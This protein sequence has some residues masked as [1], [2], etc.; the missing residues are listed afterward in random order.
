M[1][2]V[3]I[4]QDE[5]SVEARLFELFGVTSDELR[6]VVEQAA[7]ARADCVA[8]DP[9]TA[10]GTLA[11]FYGTRGLRALFRANGWERD[12][13]GGVESVFCPS[14]RMKLI[15]QNADLAAVVSHEPCSISAK[16]SASAE[17]VRAGQGWLFP[18]MAEDAEA[19]SSAHVWYLL[20]S[21]D[22]LDIRAELSRPRSIKDGQFQGF[23]ERIFILKRG[24]FDGALMKLPDDLPGDPIEVLVSRK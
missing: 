20:V 19:R 1:P 7:A 17:A 4:V 18:Y 11:Y 16:G 8:D 23:H 10:P 21:F 2:A 13:A 9:V 14:R 15:F 12:R 22:G 6:H 24:D 5:P 3:A